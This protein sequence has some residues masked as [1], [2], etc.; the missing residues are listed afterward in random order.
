MGIR[1]EKKGSLVCSRIYDFDSSLNE[2]PEAE[3]E[4]GLRLRRHLQFYFMNPMQ[5]WKLR[6]QFP[7]VLLDPSSF[8]PI[9][10][11]FKLA[12]QILKVIFVTVQLV[13]F[14]EM[15]ISHVDFLEDT[16]TVMR[17]KFLKD[18]DHDRDVRYLYASSSTCIAGSHVPTRSRPLCGLQFGRNSPAHGPHYSGG[19]FR[20]PARLVH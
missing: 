6:R 14:A 20:L 16:V 11:S 13:L 4:Y 19:K 8:I 7:S 5:K 3:K 15:R 12:F 1:K 10:F 17:H 9:A 18:W 2:L